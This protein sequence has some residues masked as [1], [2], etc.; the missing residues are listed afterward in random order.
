VA[1]KKAATAALN[2]ASVDANGDVLLLLSSPPPLLL[3]ALSL[4]G[5]AVLA[6]LP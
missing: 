4:A 5:G 2:L 6:L 3:V 1:A